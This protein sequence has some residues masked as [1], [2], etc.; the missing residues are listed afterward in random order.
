MVQIDTQ[1]KIIFLTY[2]RQTQIKQR[3]NHLLIWI[4]QL[5]TRLLRPH[6]FSEIVFRTDAMGRY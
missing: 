4:K 5:L 1:I 6:L 3:K 2:L